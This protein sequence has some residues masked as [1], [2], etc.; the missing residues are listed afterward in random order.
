[1]AI[2]PQ[3]WR[4]LRYGAAT[5]TVLLW[6][7]PMDCGF[8]AGML[9]VRYETRRPGN[10]EMINRCSETTITLTET[11]PVTL[12]LALTLTLVRTHNHNLNGN[13]HTKKAP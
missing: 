12:T 6:A 9:P 13:F 11:L 3:S 7:Q 1:M 4:G 2:H 10:T 8:T 5:G